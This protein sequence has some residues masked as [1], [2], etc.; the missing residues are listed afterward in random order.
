[1]LILGI[2]STQYSAFH[3]AHGLSSFV[4]YPIVNQMTLDRAFLYFIFLA[5]Q[6]INCQ[7][8]PSQY[9]NVHKQEQVYLQKVWSTTSIVISSTWGDRP[10]CHL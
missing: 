10:V 3:K 9:E 8:L 6:S 5:K 4:N 1:M 7:R 2:H